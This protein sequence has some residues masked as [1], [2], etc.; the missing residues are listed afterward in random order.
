MYQNGGPTKGSIELA[1]AYL[2]ET[3]A[4]K[5]DL[6]F[7]VV[8]PGRT[9][10]LEPASAAERQDWIE[11]LRAC[12]GARPNSWQSIILRS[13][14]LL[15]LG[16]KVG[17]LGNKR[18]VTDAEKTKSQFRDSQKTKWQK[19]FFVLRSGELA[20]YAR[21]KDIFPPE[22]R[23]GTIVLTGAV[24]VQESHVSSAQH[25]NAFEIIAGDRSFC[26]DVDEEE[27]KGMFSTASDEKIASKAEWIGSLLLANPTA[28]FGVPLAVAV[29]RSNPEGLVPAPIILATTWLNKHALDEEGLYRIPGARMEVERF[30]RTYDCGSKVVVP[31]QYFGGNLASLVVQ[32][33]RRCPDDLFTDQ[34]APVFQKITEDFTAKRE[35]SKQ[36]AMMK[37]LLTMLP[38][39]NLTTLRVLLEHL[40]KVAAHAEENK[41]STAKLAM[42]VYARMASTLQL[43]ME[44]YASLFDD[45][46]DG[47]AAVTL[48]VF[49]PSE[50]SAREEKAL[51]PPIRENSSPMSDLPEPLHMHRQTSGPKVEYRVEENGGPRSPLSPEDTPR[52]SMLNRV[53]DLIKPSRDR[54]ASLTRRSRSPS[55]DSRVLMPSS[56]TP[57]V[58]ASSSIG[59]SRDMRRRSTGAV[60][61]DLAKIL[62]PRRKSTVSR[63]MGSPSSEVKTLSAQSPTSPSVASVA[64]FDARM[65]GE[66]RS[67]GDGADGGL[68]F[69]KM[70]AA[71]RRGWSK[72]FV[73]VKLPAD[74]VYI[75]EGDE[76]PNMPSRVEEENLDRQSSEYEHPRYA[77][78]PTQ[79]EELRQS[80]LNEEFGIGQ[81]LLAVS[82]EGPPTSSAE[83]ESSDLESDYF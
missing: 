53:F 76:Q 72:D 28:V 45:Y 19:R 1:E 57:S 31:D 39:V 63:L 35:P 74:I 44:Q 11:G 26:L 59:I 15:K 58:A 77:L 5:R 65:S 81:E 73:G 50:S 49:S 38:P 22:K 54:S 48:P 27:E 80:Q 41:M 25:P 42:C 46:L 52:G 60:V 36:L 68:L 47:S 10:Y 55:V 9:Y 4:T 64:G 7:Q 34:Y 2:V 79:P 12:F 75:P 23:K 40:R 21:P 29:E 32:F 56:P 17:P 61:I 33:F 78:S 69:Q 62:E 8:T 24:L 18:G 6:C 16:G 51:L 14:F 71:A 3:S 43:C 67:S 20:Y 82:L 37:K 30:I 66:R 83:V 13:G 70:T